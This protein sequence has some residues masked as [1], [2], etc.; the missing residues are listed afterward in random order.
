MGRFVRAIMVVASLAIILTVS[1]TAQTQIKIGASVNGM[2]EFSS[3]GSNT[4]TFVGSCGETSCVLGDAYLGTNADTRPRWIMGTRPLILAAPNP[5]IFA[6]N[7]KYGMLNFGFSTSQGAGQGATQLTVLRDGTSASQFPSSMQVSTASYVFASLWQS[8]SVVPLNL[9]TSTAPRG[10]A[11][12]NL[13]VRGLA[14]S[15]SVAIA[16]GAFPSAPE[17]ASIAL[18]GSGLL[19]LGGVLKRRLRR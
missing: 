16:G 6:V 17:P 7:M 18:I 19:A 15:A 1:A 10:N 4:P 13:V 2:T 8:A 11:G 12:V 5:N 3:A 9:P 14:G